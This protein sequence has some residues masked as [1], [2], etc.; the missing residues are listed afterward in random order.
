MPVNVRDSAG[1][2][3]EQAGTSRD[4]A[5]TRQGQ[6]WIFPFL[7]LLV[8]TCPCLSLSVHACPCFSLSVPACPCLSL[9]VPVCPF[10]SLHF[11]YLHI[12]P[13]RWIK[14]SS[15]VWKKV[16]LQKPLFQC[17]QTLFF[18]TF[19]YNFLNNSSIQS[20]RFYS[21]D[22]YHKGHHLVFKSVFCSVN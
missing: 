20:E 21:S 6:T 19:L 22:K 18:F 2:T 11:L 3:Q 14:H 12:Y 17:M 4:R 9:S 15:F 13:C 16:T 8:P 7:S 10:M 1:T 5:G